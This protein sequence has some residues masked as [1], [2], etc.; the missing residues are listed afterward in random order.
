MAGLSRLP[1]GSF[2]THEDTNSPEHQAGFWSDDLGDTYPTEA[3]EPAYDTHPGALSPGARRLRSGF[4][5]VYRPKL[6]EISLTSTENPNDDQAMLYHF[7]D[8]ASCTWIEVRSRRRERSFRNAGQRQ[9]HYTPHFA[10][11][12]YSA[13]AEL[14]QGS[15]A[16]RALVD[17]GVQG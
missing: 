15:E 7:Y 17:F 1:T 11:K 8:P 16:T 3:D 10:E 4:K 5:T 9:L 12:V 6:K 13:E 2:S 14:R